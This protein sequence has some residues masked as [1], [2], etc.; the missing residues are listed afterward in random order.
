MAFDS[1][2]VFLERV[3]ALGLAEHSG[4]F[5][6]QGWASYGELAFATSYTPGQ[7]EDERFSKEVIEAGLGRPDHPKKAA[8]RRLFLRPI[9]WPRPTSSG[10]SRPQEMR[11]QG[12]SQRLSAM[13]GVSG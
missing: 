5:L 11:D 6:D 4:R 9:R 2:A 10:G 3:T 8:L 12:G 7:P 1:K 13:N